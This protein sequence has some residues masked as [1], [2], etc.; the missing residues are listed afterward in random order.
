[1]ASLQKQLV[2]VFM[3]SELGH[4]TEGV[5]R[6]AINELI[7]RC[8]ACHIGDGITGGGGGKLVRKKRQI[9]LVASFIGKSAA[10]SVTNLIRLRLSDHLI[11]GITSAIAS[12]AVVALLFWFVFSPG[13][14]RDYRPRSQA[15]H[16]IALLV[17][18]VPLSVRPPR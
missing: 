5:S 9:K 18:L 12:A 6:T 17:F 4:E 10:K 2:H 3:L 11:C 7:S 13:A 16:S 14:Y 8:A 1:M 15:A